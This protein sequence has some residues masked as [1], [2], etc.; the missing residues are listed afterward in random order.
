MH[1]STRPRSW[2]GGCRTH[3]RST[4]TQRPKQAPTSMLRPSQVIL[5]RL[6]WYR[7]R[8][9]KGTRESNFC[10]QK[11]IYAR[12]QSY[13]E[14]TEPFLGEE[15]WKTQPLSPLSRPAAG[16]LLLE[17]D[18]QPVKNE[19]CPW[20]A[21]GRKLSS[22]EWAGANKGAPACAWQQP[23]PDQ[24]CAWLQLPEGQ[25]QEGVGQSNWGVSRFAK[26]CSRKWSEQHLKVVNLLK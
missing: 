10:G 13:E 2:Y 17:L 19:K 14:T 11:L 15:G 21:I 6:S 25:E 1:N 26:L 5:W 4:K 8:T 9:R 16:S 23:L 24:L 7:G 12:H 20:Q 18:L 22:S 3:I